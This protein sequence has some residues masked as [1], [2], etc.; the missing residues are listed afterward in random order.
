MQYIGEM[1]FDKLFL[2][3]SCIIQSSLTTSLAGSSRSFHQQSSL[4]LAA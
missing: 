2:K 4:I 1:C 3:V